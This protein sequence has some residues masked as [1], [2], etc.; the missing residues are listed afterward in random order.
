MSDGSADLGSSRV[1]RVVDEELDTL[2]QKLPAL[3]IEVPKAV[4]KTETARR[5]TITEP[6][7][8]ANPSLFDNPRCRLPTCP[9]ATLKQLE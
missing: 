5:G 1:R 4:G 3:S 2:R 7:P 8:A 6:Y 9:N